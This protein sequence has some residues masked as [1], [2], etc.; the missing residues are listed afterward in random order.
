L[1]DV[2]EYDELAVRHNEDKMNSDFESQLP[3]PVI[4]LWRKDLKLFGGMPK[5]LSYDDPH[6]KAFLLLQGHL[7][8]V[9]SLPCSDYGPD[10]K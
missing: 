9:K 7:S 1:C 6:V 2:P 4:I 8:R 3:V 5:F 10:T